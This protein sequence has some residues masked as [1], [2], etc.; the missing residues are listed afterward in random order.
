MKKIL[1]SALALCP[2]CTISVITTDTH[3]TA[4]DV[5]DDTQSQNVTPETQISA[6]IPKIP[7]T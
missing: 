3:G 5:V 6:T 2:A 4:S 1:F 7:G